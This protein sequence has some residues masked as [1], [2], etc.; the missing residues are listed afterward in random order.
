MIDDQSFLKILNSMNTNNV[1]DT[2]LYTYNWYAFISKLEEYCKNRNWTVEYST[3]KDDASFPQQNLIIL[4]K[5]HKPE[6]LFYFFLHELGHMLMVNDDLTYNERFKILNERSQWSQTY[7][8]CR[9]EE[10]LEAWNVGLKLAGNL[11]LSINQ[12]TF[13]RLK[14]SK[15]ATYM[16]WALQRKHPHEHFSRTTR[17]LQR[18]CKDKE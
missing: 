5:R 2:N 6:I 10:E 9:V 15:V 17:T 16:L 11:G 18:I 14:A 12:P 13:E 1:V 7:R 4:S 8:V 3:E